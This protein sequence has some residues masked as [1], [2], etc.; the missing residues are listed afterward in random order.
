[1]IL[2]RKI[3]CVLRFKQVILIYGRDNEKKIYRRL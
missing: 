2:L 3:E 1:M